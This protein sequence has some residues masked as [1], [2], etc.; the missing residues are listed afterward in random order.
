MEIE[1]FCGN[2]IKILLRHREKKNI[3]NTCRPT[4]VIRENVRTSDIDEF[5]RRTEPTD[6]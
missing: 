2:Y 6:Y 1:N 3:T 4:Y 5:H